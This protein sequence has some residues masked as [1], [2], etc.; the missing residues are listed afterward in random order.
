MS[1]Q[2]SEPSRSTAAASVPHSPNFGF[3][4]KHHSLLVRY[5]AQAER[6][7]FEDA[8]LAL[9]RLR[10]FAELL[11]QQAAARVGIVVTELDDLSIV[12]SRLRERH[13]F[14]SEV[15]DLF[16][17]LRKAGN[18][19]VHAHAGDRSEALHQL[20]M[21]RSLGVWFHRAFGNDAHFK[22][23]PFL[24]PPDP[25]QAGQRL[26]EELETNR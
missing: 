25:I 2:P 22:P 3:L 1:Q 13:V 21:A 26:A 10:Q 17:G 4:A 23:G 12:L 11:A 5:A 9:I 14:T 15:L 18:A 24:P 7:V 6:F 20:R 19:A 16:H 8:N